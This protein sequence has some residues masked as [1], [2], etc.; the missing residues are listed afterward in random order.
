MEWVMERL[1]EELNRPCACEL[2]LVI[3]SALRFTLW[4]DAER[5]ASNYTYF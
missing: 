4:E 1:I 2:Q 5:E 3:V